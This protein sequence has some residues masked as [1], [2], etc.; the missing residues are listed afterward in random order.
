M[1][2]LGQQRFFVDIVPA[3]FELTLTRINDGKEIGG[4]RVDW[5]EWNEDGTFKQKHDA[6]QVGY[7]CIID[8]NRFT[9]GWLTT[10]ITEI[11]DISEE[12]IKFKT[13]NSEYQLKY[14]I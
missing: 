14:K 9:Y 8:G 1:S 12:Y 11:L 6:P 3:D 7:S 2:K 5:V 13:E 10:T 4:N